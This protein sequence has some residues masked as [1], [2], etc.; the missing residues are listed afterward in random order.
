MPNPQRIDIPF[1]S[2][3]LD[4]RYGYASQPPGTTPECLNVWPFDTQEGRQR[5]GTRPGLSKAFYEELGSGNPVRLL[6][7]V[8]FTEA[9]STACSWID[10][11]TGY[12]IRQHISASGIW[13]DFSDMAAN[14]VGCAGTPRAREGHLSADGGAANWTGAVRNAYDFLETE[15]YTIEIFVTPTRIFYHGYFSICARMDDNAPNPVTHGLEL[16]ILLTNI[17]VYSGYLYVSD[18]GV[19]IATSAVTGGTLDS[20]M[21]GWLTMTIDGDNCKC[22]WQGVLILDYTLSAPHHALLTGTR[23]GFAFVGDAVDYGAGMDCFRFQGIKATS[24]Y[25]VKTRL[26]A[27]A[28]GALYIEDPIGTM[29]EV[30]TSKT[31]RSDVP[32]SSCELAQK[33]YI[34]DYDDEDKV[35]GFDG[36][37]TG[38]SLTSS[39]AGDWTAYGISAEDDMCLI[40]DP[41]GDC[42]AGL[43]GIAAVEA[44]QITL[45]ESASG[46]AD[47]CSFRIA[48]GPKVF[49]PATGTL[50]H[51]TATEKVPPF[52]CSVVC[53]FRDRLCFA[54]DQATPYVWYMSRQGD[55]TD[56]DY[57]ADP[58][59]TGRAC[60][61][62]NSEAGVIG[63][64]ITAM[65]P[66]SDDYLIFGCESSVW[67]LRGDPAFQG[68]ID[69][70]SRNIG[71]LSQTAYCYGPEGELIFLSADGLYVLPYAA[72]QAPISLSRERLP[73][74]LMD[75]HLESFEPYL[76]F[77]VENRAVH[78]YVVGDEAFKRHH[79]WFDLQTKSYW[80]IWFDENLE[81]TAIFL[82]PLPSSG[83]NTVILGGRDGYLR[84]FRREAITD[85]GTTF[86]SYV[87]IGP[88][89]IGDGPHGDGV[90]RDM[91]ASLDETSGPIVWEL[92]PHDT[93]EL[94]AEPTLFATGLWE[95]G[96][97]FKNIPRARGS[98]IYLKLAN[99]T[100]YEPWMFERIQATI[101]QYPGQRRF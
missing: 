79:Y 41:D 39:G 8:T 51:I 92:Y 23:F 77:D 78:I 12:R 97:N 60:A 57:Y 71:I 76:I 73:Q 34:A 10:D 48:R 70:I 53:R 3:G 6:N 22:Y 45:A 9:T 91:V 52:G 16:R 65:I 85:D 19:A 21:P 99:Y 13:A 75:I 90:F 58:D 17:G 42:V 26:V 67:V 31:L 5:G 44:G 100:T 56:W 14:Q 68:Q 81:P 28:N 95:E 38:T 30:T 7:T 20:N 84:R 46:T 33:L 49:D 64:P 87:Y 93:A 11:F 29:T 25:T 63:F 18:G 88:I 98:V 69:N 82:H 2:Q 101:I 37:N 74:E 62:Q 86:D 59:D 61:G 96:L 89:Q 80:P 66:Y 4:R 15:P 27:S 40:F 72:G 50:S 43:Y 35:S 36:V 47:T 55:P 83:D 94:L 1:P 54:K 32:L 24:S